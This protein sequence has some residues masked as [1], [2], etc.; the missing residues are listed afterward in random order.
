MSKCNL[1][2]A[3]SMDTMSLKHIFIPPVQVMLLQQYLLDTITHAL[4]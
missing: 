3:L 4:W 2:Q 1:K